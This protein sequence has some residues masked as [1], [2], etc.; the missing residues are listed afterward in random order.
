M[1]PKDRKGKGKAKDTRGNGNRSALSVD[2]SL[3]NLSL[4]PSTARSQSPTASDK[5]D[6]VAVIGYDRLM[7]KPDMDIKAAGQRIFDTASYSQIGDTLV[8]GNSLGHNV[9]EEQEEHRRQFRAMGSKIDSQDRRIADLEAQLKVVKTASEGY[10]QIRQR[11][12]DTF[13]RDILRAPSIVAGNKAA[14]DGDAVTDA[15]LYETGVRHDASLLFK[16]YGLN[17]D[18]I[19]KLSQTGDYDSINIIN[20]RATLKSDKDKMVPE[21][22]E[23]AWK[24][25][26]FKLEE[27]WGQMPGEDPLSPLTRAYYKF[28]EVHGTRR[29]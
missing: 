5:G 2:L 20:A 27:Y 22:I 11:F 13:R 1:P 7:V 25:Y 17:A 9:L 3:R 14:H 26:V 23:E 4:T 15:S 18:Q 24:D 6:D 19:L 28:W 21:D 10:L 29:R 12:L 8:Y 16:I